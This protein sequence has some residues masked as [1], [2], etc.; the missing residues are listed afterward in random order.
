MFLKESLENF[1]GLHEEISKEIHGRFC[2]GDLGKVSDN[3]IIYLETSFSED[4][5][6]YHRCWDRSVGD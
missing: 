6:F 1:I 2:I 4:F 3:S 5:G